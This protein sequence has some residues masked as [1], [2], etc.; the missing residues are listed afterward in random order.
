MG[1]SLSTNYNQR[2]MRQENQERML[3][4]AFVY[5]SLLW[6]KGTEQPSLEVRN[7]S[8]RSQNDV[9]LMFHLSLLFKAF[10]WYEL[11]PSTTLQ[12]SDVKRQLHCSVSEVQVI[13]MP[14]C[15]Q[16]FL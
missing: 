8:I 16:A 6:R 10:N 12:F 15:A 11:L 9:H 5:H 14:D 3:A 13:R 4:Y 1:F 7:R 2:N